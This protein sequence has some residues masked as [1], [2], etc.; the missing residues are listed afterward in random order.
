M[1]PPVAPPAA[2]LAGEAFSANRLG[3]GAVEIRVLDGWRARLAEPK[4]A[5]TA[6]EDLLRMWRPV[7]N[8][9]FLLM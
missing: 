5:P 9:L 7:I 3:E 8:L 6:R 2:L 1:L 4:G